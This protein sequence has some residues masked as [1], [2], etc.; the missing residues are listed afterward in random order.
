MKFDFA[1]GNPAYNESFTDD[2]N[3]TFAPPVYHKFIDAACEIA[4]KV[5]MVHP[6]RFLFNAGSTPKAWNEKMLND[7]HFKVLEY[8]ENGQKL[9]SNTEIKGGIAITYHDANKNFGAIE[10][11]TKYPELNTILHKV[12]YSD[13]LSDSFYVQNKYNLNTLYADHPEYK[14][15]IGSNGSDKRFRSNSFDKVPV[16]TDKPSKETDIPILGVVK[17]KRVIKYIPEKYIDQTHANLYKWKVLIPTASG[18]G[19]YGE[20]LTEPV[21]S[22]PRNAY[23]QTFIGVGNYN[24]E[25]EAVNL[26]RYLK[27][28]FARALMGVLK[29]TQH[30]TPDVWKYVPKQDFTNKSDINWNSSIKKVDQQLYKKYNLTDEEIDFIETHVKEME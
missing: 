12:D 3:E 30:I 9:F 8:E 20:T 7:P 19:Q 14:E 2:G 17:N 25:T 15:F 21:V 5:E 22:E 16:F 24:N 1:I 18:N 13:S 23:T 4:D 27:T 28:K 26:K 11:F 29:I 10:V 6:A